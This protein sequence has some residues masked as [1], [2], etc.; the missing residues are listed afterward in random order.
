V[1]ERLARRLTADPDDRLLYPFLAVF[2]LYLGIRGAFYGAAL[3]HLYLLV[4][5]A[6]LLLPPV[7]RRAAAV[8]ALVVEAALFREHLWI[9]SNHG[10][11]EVFILALTAALPA[12]A[13]AARTAYLRALMAILFVMVLWTGA[14]KVL[15]GYYV[16]G[17]YF[18][19][20]MANPAGKFDGLR[21]LLSDADRATLV[22]Y[23]KALTKFAHAGAPGL[24]DQPVP[25]LGAI[26][27][28]SK[29]LCWLTLAAELGLPFLLIPRRTRRAAIVGLL[30]F[31][32]GVELFAWEWHFGLLV[33]ALL[34]PFV[35]L[36]NCSAPQEIGPT[37]GPALRAAAIVLL[38]A[39]WPLV[40][41]WLTATRDLS[42]WKL[43]GMAMYSI[44]GPWEAT[45][46]D[47]RVRGDPAWKP[48][49]RKG[50]GIPENGIKASA[51]VLLSA[52]FMTESAHSIAAA[53]RSVRP[54]VE[55]VRVRARSVVHDR[56]ADRFRLRERTY[57]FP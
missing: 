10:F 20:E 48:F 25:L 17:D 33:V 15:Y 27:L 23:Q 35:P 40:Q 32:L 46:V 45:K 18:V 31:F 1:I 30:V 16:P 42:P 12:R 4:P 24:F 34:V 43:G 44:P 54:D 51:D 49:P 6:I 56:S 53:V 5:A 7:T 11:I 13:L 14:K 57:E 28:V 47:V 52:P 36:R 39:L 29:V 26:P 37:R 9:I 19:I 38:F 3:P 41:V 55:A 22:A 21:A 8:A 50:P 2:A